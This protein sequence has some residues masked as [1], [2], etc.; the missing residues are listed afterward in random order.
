[1]TEDATTPPGPPR[2]EHHEARLERTARHIAAEATQGYEK[3]LRPAVIAEMQ[4][5]LIFD[6]LATDEGREELERCLDPDDP[7]DPH[8][9]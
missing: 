5:I 8:I 6:M 9:R 7:D 2:D 4:R 1:M 3:I